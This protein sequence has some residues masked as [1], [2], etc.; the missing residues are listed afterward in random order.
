MLNEGTCVSATCFS[1]NDLN[2]TNSYNTALNTVSDHSSALATDIRAALDALDATPAQNPLDLNAFLSNPMFQQMMSNPDVMN[3]LMGAL[4]GGDRPQPSAPSS[5]TRSPP[6]RS[7]SSSGGGAP[8]NPMAMLSDPAALNEFLD[9]PTIKAKE[10]DP[11]LGP[12][13]ADLRTNG[14][15]SIAKHLG[16][17]AIMAKLSTLAQELSR[18]QGAS[19]T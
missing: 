13:I 4:M 7:A 18:T 11:E 19:S 15:G 17:P 6:P 14:I 10:A 12:L 8:F 3:N 16:N 5:G 9:S 1:L 2:G